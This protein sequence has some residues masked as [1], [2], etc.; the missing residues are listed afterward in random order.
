MKVLSVNEASL[1]LFGVET[2]EA[3]LGQ[4]VAIFCGRG[5]EPF[6]QILGAAAS[7]ERRI[8]T[9]LISETPKGEL[10]NL[11]VVCSIAPECQ[12]SLARVFICMVDVSERN[13]MEEALRL[14]N[15]RLEK[16]V[17]ERTREL[18]Q[19]TQN[20]EE[21]NSALRVLLKQ[22]SV[23]KEEMAES[24]LSNIKNLVAPYL[25]KL[26][27]SRLSADQAT[28]VSILEAH[29][30]EITSPFIRKFSQAF[31]NLTPTEIRIAEMIRDGMTTKE[32]ADIMRLAPSTILSH[33]ENMR[34]KLGLRGKKINLRSYLQT[35]H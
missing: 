6:A 27:K 9:E 31:L 19:K 23:D 1:D 17:E 29:I 35:I 10:R 14:A 33:R 34:N 18:E 15:E 20:M 5:M 12:S 26:R 8:E 3:L 16:T 22:R 7:G 32:M 24:V 28:Y 25:E 4:A 11:N 13:R 30:R 21:V 2:P